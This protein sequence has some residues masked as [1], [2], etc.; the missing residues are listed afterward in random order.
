MSDDD[1][2]FDFDGDGSFDFDD[3]IIF[4]WLTGNDSGSGTGCGPVLLSAVVHGVAA[5]LVNSA[6]YSVLGGAVAGLVAQGATMN[7]FNDNASDAAKWITGLVVGGAVA[8]GV[9]WCCPEKESKV[10]KQKENKT[11]MLMAEPQTPKPVSSVN[12]LQYA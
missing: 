5:G 9:A 6:W 8:A 12:Y 1:S 3:W 2:F 10:D 4:D 11:T 7:C